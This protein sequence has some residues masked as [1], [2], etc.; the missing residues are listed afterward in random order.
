MAKLCAR[1][2]MDLCRG[3]T[4]LERKGLT[5]I[6]KVVVTGDNLRWYAVYTWARHEKVV[7]RHFE[8]RRVAHFLPL[9]QAIHR[10]NKRSARVSLPLF[11]GYVFVQTNAQDRNKALR[12]PAVVHYVGTGAAPS[13]IPDD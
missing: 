8:E 12:V 6:Q 2:P 10:W 1:N 13:P 5:S 7:A 3:T 11:P 4:S 9:Y